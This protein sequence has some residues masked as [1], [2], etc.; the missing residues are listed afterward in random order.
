MISK[1]SKK[2]IIFFLG[3]IL[4]LTLGIR[5]ISMTNLGLAFSDALFIELASI[6]NVPLS[7][8][9]LIVG[10]L[11]LLC[12]SIIERR[13]IRIECLISSF[14]LGFFVDFWM[15]FFPSFMVRGVFLNIIVFIV[16]VFVLSIGISIYLQPGFPPHPNDYLF[17]KISERFNFSLFKSKAI[18]DGGF[19][20]CALL[21]GAPIGI[22]SLFNT[23]CL[24]FFINK[25]F[26][27]FKRVYNK[28]A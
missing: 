15:M 7:L 22:G 28:K 21:I 20:I 1:I 11:T 10:I 13:R 17:M 23:L 16:G 2:D 26:K 6:L 5:I 3:G 8:S 18:M 14:I 9:S 25:A 19:F 12:A 4:I 27:I 24:G